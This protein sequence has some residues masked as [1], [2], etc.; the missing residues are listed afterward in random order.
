MTHRDPL[1]R[2]RGP[3]SRVKTR[4]RLRP[5]G[6]PGE[7]L[8]HLP[9]APRPQG[10]NHNGGQRHCPDS[11]LALRVL[12]VPVSRIYA[13]PWSRSSS[14]PRQA[15]GFAAPQPAV[16]DQAEQR[17]Q[18]LALDEV[19]KRPGMIR[20]PHHHRGRPQRLVSPHPLLSTVV[21]RCSAEASVTRR[22]S[23]AQNADSRSPLHG[24]GRVL[25]PRGRI[26]PSHGLTAS[27]PGT[28]ALSAA[29]S[30]GHGAP[31]PAARRH[32]ALTPPAS[33]SAAT[34]VSRCPCLMRAP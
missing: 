33:L 8:L 25:R 20:Q 26:T 30:T 15:N 12:A 11:S 10:G 13:S 6:T 22:S 34:P 19:E 28:A 17:V 29:V 14:A 27:F 31:E 3:S 5:V 18:P 4:A 9:L 16:R 2:D 24:S 21:G 1:R 32:G 23:A 7:L